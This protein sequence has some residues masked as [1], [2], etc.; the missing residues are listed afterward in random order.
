MFTDVS[1]LIRNRV[2]FTR[3]RKRLDTS[4]AG[5]GGKKREKGE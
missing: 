4:V 5:N 3:L 1:T 2:N